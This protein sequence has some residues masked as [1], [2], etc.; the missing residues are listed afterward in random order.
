[1][2]ITNIV[3]AVLG[4]DQLKWDALWRLFAWLL[5]D[6]Q[7][8]HALGTQ[9]VEP[10][11]LHAFGQPFRDYELKPEFQLSDVRDGKGKWPDLAVAIPTFQAPTHML[12][13][14]G[15]CRFAV[16]GRKAQAR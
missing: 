11:F 15:R 7:E 5:D 14:H 8:G 6:A 1:M 4:R 13:S 3:E 9:I 2:P 12:A 10:L 16:A